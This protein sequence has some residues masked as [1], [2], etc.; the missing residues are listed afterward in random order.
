MIKVASTSDEV[1]NLTTEFEL[2]LNEVTVNNDN[3]VASARKYIGNL[4]AGNNDEAKSQSSAKKASVPQ[5][6]ASQVS[7]TSSQRKKRARASKTQA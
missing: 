1:E 4:E 7:K 3:V 2:W 5:S 6:N